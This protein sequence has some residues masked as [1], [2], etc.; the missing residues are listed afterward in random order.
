MRRY[1]VATLVQRFN[2]EKFR[3]GWGI[4]SAEKGESDFVWHDII[5]ATASEGVLLLKIAYRNGRLRLIP[6]VRQQFSTRSARLSLLLEGMWS[7]DNG[8]GCI[9]LFFENENQARGA[10]A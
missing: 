6:I 10:I 7:Q 4:E 8:Y 1:V 9:E 3:Y 2:Q 5:G